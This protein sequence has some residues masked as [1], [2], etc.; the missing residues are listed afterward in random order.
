MVASSIKNDPIYVCFNKLKLLTFVSYFSFV[1]L[2]SACSLLRLMA[3]LDRKM[4]V[5]RNLYY[6]DF[7]KIKHSKKLAQNTTFLAPTYQQIHSFSIF[8]K[9]LQQKVKIKVKKCFKL[10]KFVLALEGALHGCQTQRLCGPL[11][12]AISKLRLRNLTKPERAQVKN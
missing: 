9:E 2:L 4:K 7:S 3:S 5:K 6:R 11:V 10:L 8:Q 1:Q 12:A